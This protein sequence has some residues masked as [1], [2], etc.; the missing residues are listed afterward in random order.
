MQQVRGCTLWGVMCVASVALA[1]DGTTGAEA[2]GQAP[3]VG[4][5]GT[6]GIMRPWL[7]ERGLYTNEYGRLLRLETPWALIDQRNHLLVGEIALRPKK[8]EGAPPGP[9]RIPNYTPQPPADFEDG[10]GPD[11]GFEAVPGTGWVPADCAMAVGPGHIVTVVN[12]QVSFF[13]K[14]GVNTF[15]RNLA[16]SMGFW[17]EQGAQGLVF[18]PET[19]YDA[20]S[21]RYWVMACEQN[22]SAGFFTLAV[23]DDGDPN[24][25]WHKYRIN[26]THL[27]GRDID[28]PNMSITPNAVYLSAD[29]QENGL[30]TLVYVLPKAPLLSGAAPGPG[31]SVVIPNLKGAGLPTRLDVSSEPQYLIDAPD[32]ATGSTAVR[33]YAIQNPLSSPTATVVST[34]VV[35]YYPPG[36]PPQ[37]G[38]TVRPN[39]YGP[40][41]WSAVQRGGSVWAV[42]HIRKP[43][44]G[45]TT[46]RWYEF[47]MNGWPASGIA[48]A[49]LHYGDID[50]GAPAHAFCPSVGVDTVGNAAIT[51]ARSSGQEYIS[52][53]RALRRGNDLPGV[54]REPVVVKESSA[55]F[56]IMERWG[57][58]STT[59]ADPGEPCTF[60]GHHQWTTSTDDWRTW[61]ARYQNRPRADMD[62]N[63][64]LNIL[65]FVAFLSAFSAHD[66][67][68][69]MNQDGLL[70]L[71]DFSAFLAAFAAG[72]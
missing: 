24:G 15:R 1:G 45:R 6:A 35:L 58:Y 47:S 34:P 67:R 43:G 54:F 69:D 13:T 18:D 48:P 10:G 12:G 63:C 53:W 50:P 72:D 61:V 46:V 41:F 64:T 20:H 14:D 9:R 66:M 36:A 51:F 25:A 65:D 49:V 33:F 44:N 23:S 19:H 68:A 37:M 21:N 32:I 38:T 40:R 71:A 5:A 56:T 26:V 39:L 60:W 30:K 59:V 42:H 3:A 8:P 28:S 11:F 27:A 16:G 52:I 62:G 22:G 29:F 2:G 4:W 70:N 31:S 17:V 7:E 57:D 55:P